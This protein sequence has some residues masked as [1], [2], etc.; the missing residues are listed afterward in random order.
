MPEER[1]PPRPAHKPAHKAAALINA[2]LIRKGYAL[3]AAIR[4]VAESP[5]YRCGLTLPH[6]LRSL[7]YGELVFY[8]AA[9]TEAD[10]HVELCGALIDPDG[11]ALLACLLGS[12]AWGQRMA[13]AALGQ[14]LVAL[15]A[16]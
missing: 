11:D 10:D 16:Y 12:R 13:K 1:L 6:A 3:T 2:R 4:Y 7:D 5:L 9:G 8:V 14:E 15:L